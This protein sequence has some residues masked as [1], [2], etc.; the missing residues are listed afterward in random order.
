MDPIATFSGLASGVQWRDLIDQILQV[1]RRPAALVEQQIT[2]I[3][4]KSAAWLTFQT[5][6]G[7]FQNAVVGLADGTAFE[8]FS[9]TIYGSG[10]S[11]SAASGAS[12]GSYSVEV[13]RLAAAE[14]VGGDI[15]ASTSTA[16]GQ[17]GEFWINGARIEIDTGDSLSDVAY[18]INAAN[19]GTSAT[20]VSAAI[21]AAGGGYQLVLTSQATGAAGIDLVDGADGVARGLGLTDAQVA[22][23]HATSNGATS[24]AFS[25]SSTAVSTLRGLTGTSTGNVTIGSGSG[26]F[27][28]DVDLT[29]SLDQIAADIQAAATAAG[30]GVTASVVS[31]TVA[32]ATRYRLDLGGTT[33]FTDAGGVLQTLGV[34]EGGRGTVAQVITSGSALQS[35]GSAATGATELTALDGGAQ[36]GDTF[37]VAGTKADGSAFGLTLTVADP[38]VPASGTVKTLDDV[39]AALNGAN[40]YDG[41]ATASVVDGRI[42]VTDASGGASQLDLSIVTHNEGGGTLDFGDFD[43]TTVG[44]RREIVAG[45]DA[46]VRID[47]VYSTHATNSVASAIPGVNLSLTAVTSEAGVLT[48]SRNVDAAVS[49]VKALVSTYNE[50]STFVTGQFSGGE[51]STQPLAGDSTL[52]SMMSQVR[53]TM[54][55][56]LTTGVG[57]SWSR[58]GELGVQIQRD[59]KFE[60][61]EST[62]RDAL[63]SDPTAVQ[64]LFGE[65]GST[66]GP[67]LSWVGDTDATVAGTYTVSVTA[68]ATV[69]TLLGSTNLA[70][71]FDAADDTLT[72]TDL[73]TGKSY[74]VAL[75]NGQSAASVLADVQAE[76]ATEKVHRIASATALQVDAIGTAATEDTTWGEV[77]Q[78]G[79]TAGVSD[80]DTITVSGRR[81]DGTS[82]YKTLYVADA[83]TQTVGELKDLV[84]NAVGGGATVELGSDGKLVIT[85]AEAGSSLLELT[86]SSDNEGG[87]SLQIATEVTQ[88]GRAAARV[89]A[90]LEGG[91]LKLTHQDYGSSAGFRIEF[92]NG[93]TGTELG[94]GASG[95]EYAG[96]DVEG[97][98]GGL[99]ATGSGRVL[100]GAADTDVEGLAIQVTDAF[101]AGSVSYSRGVAA[102]LALVLDAFLGTDQGSIQSLLDGLDDRVDSLS[103]RVA[104]MDARLER[105]QTDLIRR[106]TAMEQAMAVAQNQS[107][108]IAAQIGSLPTYSSSGS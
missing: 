81:A 29:R 34:L 59:G 46:A 108:W 107:A 97:T 77:F 75:V 82:F 92:A 32:G 72:I 65:H 4:A 27:T 43:A 30:S 98:I 80:G 21:V 57:G 106:F 86:I 51:G 103:D 89:G 102:Q 18:A 7:A 20:G 16:L 12:P 15:V 93:A 78:G 31:E 36:L 96:T 60:L 28:V 39:V 95:T 85:A 101:T 69:A 26:V 38:A 19:T 67:G 91:A 11:G 41:T 8:K 25:S 61:T 17:A 52:R 74:A 40:G 55:A 33:S 100:T 10:F 63:A 5:K 14:K 88:E 49:T 42:V 9:T 94:L 68:P 64:R 13:L 79:S 45:V 105:R 58:L 53:T 54:Q 35:G 50:V 76:L 56:T 104:D 99:A 37:T 22:I 2:G 47:G 90:S 24:D 6:L 83:S 23:K 70:D 62:L 44:R 48:V 3:Q 84:Q 66:T 71:G 1:E 87:G 73:G